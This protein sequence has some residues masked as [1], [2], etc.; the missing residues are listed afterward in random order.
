MKIW[1]RKWATVSDG[2]FFFITEEAQ[3]ERE[4]KV[5]VWGKVETEKRKREY[6][7]NIGIDRQADR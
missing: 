7:I 4:K 2:G 5:E 6:W 3:L 1:L